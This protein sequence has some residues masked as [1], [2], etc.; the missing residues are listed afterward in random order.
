VGWLSRLFGKVDDEVDEPL[1]IVPIPPLVTL[2]KQHEAAKGSPLTEQEVLDIRGKAICM[3]MR[4]SRADQLAAARG[5][6]DID[7]ANAWTE[8]VEVRSSGSA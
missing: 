4:R 5:F 1:V 6:P 2:L 3:T 7:P 8:W